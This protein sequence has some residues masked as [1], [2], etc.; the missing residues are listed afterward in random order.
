[1]SYFVSGHPPFRGGKREVHSG[2]LA[3]KYTNVTLGGPSG[4]DRGSD[5]YPWM[6][7]AAMVKFVI[8]RL[9][10]HDPQRDC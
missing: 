2:H 3:G 1:M 7:V 4:Q 10:S 8:S 9:R 6:Y 5:Y